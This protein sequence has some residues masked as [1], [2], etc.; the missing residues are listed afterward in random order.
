MRQRGMM[1]IEV[2]VTIIVVS[3]GLLGVAGVI[4]NSIKVNDSS[5]S[6]AQA[7]WFANDIIDRM[8]ANRGAAEAVG[9]PYNVA[10]NGT[11]Q[12]TGVPAND[13]TEWL[14]TIAATLPSGKGS[15]SMVSATKKV[16]VMVQWDDWRAIGNGPSQPSAECP[17]PVTLRCFVMETRL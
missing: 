10:L 15:V 4:L 5:G 1:M 14:G 6:R 12:G 16:T 8:R 13:L 11:P 17:T 2:M 7:A 3:F 9:L